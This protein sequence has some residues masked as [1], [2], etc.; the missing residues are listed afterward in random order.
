MEER[1]KQLRVDMP[2]AEE[3]PA[4][5][6]GEGEGGGAWLTAVIRNS[7]S[8]APQV[9]PTQ[10]GETEPGRAGAGLTIGCG[11]RAQ[12]QAEPEGSE[13]KPL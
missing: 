12:E 10:P 8:F 13:R 9:L 4:Q 3:T 1:R 5:A 6:G 7:S 2:L 11:Q